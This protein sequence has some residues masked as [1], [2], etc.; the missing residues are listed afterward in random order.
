MTISYLASVNPGVVKRPNVSSWLVKWFL[1]LKSCR[2]FRFPSK[3]IQSI[4]DTFAHR[5]FSGAISCNLFT[6]M[7][8]CC[9][10]CFWC[11]KSGGVEIEG[12]S[13]AELG[14]EELVASDSDDCGNACVFASAS[15]EIGR[16]ARSTC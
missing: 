10:C 16:Y 3:S 14:V 12:P 15:W 11:L 9:S 1:G 5:D 8:R 4:A 13:I 7:Q 2:G 6:N